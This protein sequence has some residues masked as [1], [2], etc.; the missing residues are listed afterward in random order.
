LSNGSVDEA[1][2]G[3]VIATYVHPIKVAILEAMSWIGE[4]LS[5][6]ECSRMFPPRRHG[7]GVVSYHM[8]DLLKAGLVED[9]NERA[10]RGARE[11][12]YYLVQQ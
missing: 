4:P 10:A 2:W 11:T 12:Y 5:S 8:A 9:T 7:L 1:D 6:T 3:K